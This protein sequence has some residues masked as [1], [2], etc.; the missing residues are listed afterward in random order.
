MRSRMGRASCADW[1]PRAL[2]A[3][4]KREII[5]Y[6][7][8]LKLLPNAATDAA[9]AYALAWDARAA[10]GILRH[11]TMALT[12]QDVTRMARL[13]RIAVPDQERAAVL[14]DLNTIFGLIE[15]LQAVDTDGV[16]PMAHPLSVLGEVQLRLRDD[17][18]TEPTNGQ[19]R[20]RL[21]ANAPAEHDGLFL[22]PKV[23]E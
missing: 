21:L 3:P 7:A 19:D 20:P 10:G 22:V 8:P 23:I 13:A 6:N 9:Q 1:V 16:E 17:V 14:G 11:T 2:K 5:T 12:E 15:Q 4:I 18:V